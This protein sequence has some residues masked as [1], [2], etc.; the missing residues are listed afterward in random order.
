MSIN[1]GSGILQLQARTVIVP[2]ND[3]EVKARLRELEQPI[4][5]Y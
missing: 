4:C 2:T 5:K 3:A 1:I